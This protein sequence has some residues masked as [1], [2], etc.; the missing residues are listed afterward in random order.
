M[1]YLCQLPHTTLNEGDLLKAVGN[2][3]ALEQLTLLLGERI[4]GDLPLSGGQT[5][6]SLLLTNKSIINKSLG[7]FKF[8]RNFRLYGNPCTSK[9]NRPF[10]GTQFGV[11]V[12]R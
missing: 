11:E 3:K 2:D 1:S 10:P 9:R 7:H 5:L 6:Q 4:E 12:W 8:T